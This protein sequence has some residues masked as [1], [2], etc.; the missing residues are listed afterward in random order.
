MPGAAEKRQDGS[1]K[2]QRGILQR[3]FLGRSSD[4]ESL[5]QSLADASGFLVRSMLTCDG[6]DRA[7]GLFAWVRRAPQALMLHRVA[8]LCLLVLSAFPRAL[9]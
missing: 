1:P 7:C 4:R 3:G 9:V 6:F 5:S 8:V 2:R